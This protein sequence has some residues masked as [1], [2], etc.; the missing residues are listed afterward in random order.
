MY[1]TKLPKIFWSFQDLQEKKVRV[2]YWKV[3]SYSAVLI[4]LCNCATTA[5]N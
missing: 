2:I 5:F 1:F 3:N 4:F